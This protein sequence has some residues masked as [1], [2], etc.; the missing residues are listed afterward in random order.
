MERQRKILVAADA[1]NLEFFE[2]MLSKL[3]YEVLTAGTGAAALEK[4]RQNSPDLAILGTALPE[5]SCWEILSR[6]KTGHSLPVEATPVILLSDDTAGVKERVEAFERGAEDYISKPYNFTEVLARIRSILRTRELL[7]QLAARE[8]R[9]SLAETLY[10]DLKKTIAL[11][12]K[13]IASLNEA[14]ELAKKD[15]LNE[16]SMPPIVDYLGARIGSVY[17]DAA[18]IGAHVDTALHEWDELKKG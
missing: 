13:N 5:L 7:Q 10:G 4:I 16:N 18:A 17:T 9:L 11:F 12:L 3:G 6:L 1:A 14:I 8:S 15:V 2:V